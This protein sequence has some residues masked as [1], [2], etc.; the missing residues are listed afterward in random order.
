MNSVVINKFYFACLSVYTNFRD[1]NV[2]VL[3]E[4]QS[5]KFRYMKVII[6]NQL[7]KTCIMFIQSLNIGRKTDLWKHVNHDLKE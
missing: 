2:M 3:I 7:Q 1:K 6:T 4:R 5:M